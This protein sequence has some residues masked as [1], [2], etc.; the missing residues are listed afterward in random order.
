MLHHRFGKVFV[1]LLP[2]LFF[3]GQIFAQMTVTG[4]ITGTVMDACGQVVQAAKVTIV[5]QETGDT[6]TV[7]MSEL[8]DFSFAA[9][10]PRTY[11]LKVEA[12]GF[13]TSQRTEIVLS[14]NQHVAIGNSSLEVGAVTETVNVTAQSAMVETSSSEQ[15][16]QATTN[17]IENLTALVRE[18]VSLLRTIPGVTCQADQDSPGGTYGT[19]TPNIRGTNVYM[20]L[21]AEAPPPDRRHR[22][23]VPKV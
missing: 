11:S 18:V 9:V 16:N 15:C 12:S 22:Y 5:S 13:E 4:A 19:A 8:S 17:Q 2:A 20:N 1:C 14:A 6:R 21:P 23:L 10:K 3:S 7:L